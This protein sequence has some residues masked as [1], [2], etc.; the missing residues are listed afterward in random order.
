MRTNQQLPMYIVWNIAYMEEKGRN[1]DLIALF[2]ISNGLA[3]F[4]IF[5]KKIHMLNNV[6]LI[7]LPCKRY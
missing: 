3:T 7:G 6:R 1:F 2:H 4:F 5:R